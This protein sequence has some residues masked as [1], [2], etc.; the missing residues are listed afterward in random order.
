MANH[1]SPASYEFLLCQLVEE[2]AQDGVVFQVRP[3]FGAGYLLVATP[4]EDVQG[5]A[6]EVTRD[7]EVVQHG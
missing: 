2:A 5:D 3:N 4:S 7:R 6:M 1:L